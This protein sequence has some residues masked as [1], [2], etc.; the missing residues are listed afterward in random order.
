M[1]K[2]DRPEFRS[3]VIVVKELVSE[4]PDVFVYHRFY[5]RDK[6]KTFEFQNPTYMLQKYPHLFTAV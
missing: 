1:L 6:G 5:V 3:G 4:N 2:F